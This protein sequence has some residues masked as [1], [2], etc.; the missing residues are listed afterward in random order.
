MPSVA[1]RR[2]AAQH[3]AR[4]EFRAPKDLVAWLGAVQAQ[5][6]GAT[7][8]ALGLRLGGATESAVE[9]AI[10]N[11]SVIRTH[12]LRF[13]WQ[14][15]APEDVR[16]M[17]ALVAPR[18]RARIA[19]RHRQLELD[20]ATIRRSNAALEKALRGGQHL[21]RSEL[22]VALT[23]ARVSS[24]GQRLAHLLGCAEL[25]GLICGGARRGKQHTYALLEQR[26]AK[27]AKQLSREESAAELGRRYF[28]SRG[29]ASVADF[30]WWSGLS[31][32]DARAAIAALG[33][34]LVSERVDGQTLWQAHAAPAAARLVVSNASLLP[35]FDEYLVGYRDRGAVLEPKHVKRLNA[36]GGMLGPCIVLRGRV[37]GGWRRE[38]GRSHVAVEL[39]LFEP[40]TRAE[41]SAIVRAA[42]RF[43]EFLGYPVTRTS[44]VR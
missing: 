5:D 12:A 4:H 38:L 10:A 37:V 2:L 18:L 8:W 27:R 39:D 41:R 43:G 17:L 13:T 9:Q 22:A 28:Q 42:E 25:D 34:E 23:R 31:P 24:A 29:P 3:I 30:S 33:S 40:A 1:A 36:G 35:A 20:A 44:W 21:T 14:L 15:V 19:A 11:G 32:A 7:K 16:W 26:V 6:Y